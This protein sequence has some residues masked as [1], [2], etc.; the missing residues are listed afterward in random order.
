MRVKKTLTSSTDL[1]RFTVV[2]TDGK[3]GKLREILFN[4]S[5]WKLQHA[6]VS[7]GDWAGE[8]QVLLDVPLLHS[9]EYHDRVIRVSSNREQLAHLPDAQTELPVA[10]RMDLRLRASL[11]RDVRWPEEY[12]G[13]R[14]PSPDQAIASE[15]VSPHLRSTRIL[16]GVQV[17]SSD[18]G[19]VG[20]IVSFLCDLE[21][22]AIQFL[23]CRTNDKRL[24][25]L[26]PFA[27]AHIDVAGR[28]LYV[29]IDSSTIQHMEEL[30]PNHANVV[31][32][33]EEA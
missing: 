14:L 24:V 12:I 15:Q 11:A 13:T 10:R 28:K 16:R 22:A 1:E 27:V 8:R 2:A 20:A 26:E 9:P 29:R 31:E 3:A 6:V 4:D 18:G 17:V 19:V 25:L 33:A 32:V 23:V 5:T 30:D 21:K 7:L